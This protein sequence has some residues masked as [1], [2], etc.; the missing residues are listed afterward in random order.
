MK[1]IKFR[2]GT[3]LEAAWNELQK[4]SEEAKETCC[5]MFNGTLIYSTDTLDEVF[6]E[7]IGKTKAEFDR[8]QRRLHESRKR[9]ERE[10]EK[11]IPCL[12]KYYI[13]K[14]RGIIR[15]EKYE[16]WKLVV[17]IRLR[18]LYHGSELQST[19]ELCK[20]MKD[21]NLTFDARMMKA[22]DTFENQDHSGASGAL[23]CGLLK[24]FCPLGEALANFIKGY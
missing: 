21:N 8:D 11:R 3:S 20:I 5:G 4:Q 19:L 1:E 16:Y 13:E 18:D 22:R 12:T 9:S 23:V 15:Q 7:I 17:P 2:R 6:M 10:F 14:A 24:E